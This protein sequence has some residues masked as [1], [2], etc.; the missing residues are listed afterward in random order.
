MTSAPAGI[1]GGSAESEGA[2]YRA[3]DRVA[4]SLRERADEAE[5]LRRMLGERLYILI[6]KGCH[7]DTLSFRREESKSR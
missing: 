1:P 6:A 5:K 3:F 2:L 4:E 7:M